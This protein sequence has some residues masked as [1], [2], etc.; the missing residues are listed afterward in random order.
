[1]NNVTYVVN[2]LDGVEYAVVDNGDG[3]FN[4]MPKSTYDAMLAA[5]VA[6]LHLAE[7]PA[8]IESTQP[9]E[10]DLTEGNN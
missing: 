7:V 1:M 2:E 10:A 3:S 6:N 4:S 9:D 5:D 8:T